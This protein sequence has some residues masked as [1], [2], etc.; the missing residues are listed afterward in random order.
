[1]GSWL[2]VLYAYRNILVYRNRIF[3][4]TYFI[5]L[6]I[7]LSIPLVACTEK[8]YSKYQ[9]PMRCEQDKTYEK[10]GKCPVCEMDLK[11]VE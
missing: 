5:V 8:K 7:F 1:M 3:M 11:G 2:G 9:C 4:K 10:P 6:S